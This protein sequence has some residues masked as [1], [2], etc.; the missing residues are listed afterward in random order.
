MNR[1]LRSTEGILCIVL[2]GLL[3]ICLLGLG[4]VL[5][6]EQSLPVFRDVTMEL[7]QPLPAVSAF[8]TERGDPAKAMRVT[9]DEELDLSRV[10]QQQV[11][12]RQN[13]REET[14][15]LTIVDT[16]APAVVSRLDV[17][18]ALGTKPQAQALIALVTDHSPVTISFVKEPEI[19]KNFGTVVME[20]AVTDACGNATTVSCNVHY[21]WL[22]G[23]FALELGQT[24]TVAD[25]LLGEMDEDYFVDQAAVDAIN[26]SGIGVYPVTSTCGDVSCQC[27][28]TVQDTTAPTLEVQSLVLEKGET[29][30]AEEFVIAATDLSGPVT[31]GFQT[32][33]DFEQVGQQTV[34]ITGTDASGNIATAE[35]TLDIKQDMTA[36]V[37]QGLDNMRVEIGSSPDYK[38]GV[39]AVDNKDGNVEFTV[40]ASLEDTSK[41]GGFFVT[42]TAT[43]AAGNTTT[44]RRWI[45]VDHDQSDVEALVAKYADT[46]PDDPHQI[47]IWL[48]QNIIY[49]YAWGDGDPVWFG[50]TKWYGNCYVHAHCLQAILEHKGYETQLIWTTGED[51]YWVLVNIGGEGEAAVW[52]HLDSTPGEI[53]TKYG[54]MDD[55]HRLWTLSGGRV[56]D[57]DQWPACE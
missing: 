40:D 8:L 54:L 16:T 15:T 57:F 12:F 55:E 56:W 4:G 52:R 38:L 17:N 13:G 45:V 35:T 7:G 48:Q 31:L 37:F 9:T 25:L 6:L 46:L 11:I 5:Y 20:V 53:H 14:V 49:D 19:P 29:A 36:P 30:A 18:L 28:V 1:L 2:I 22:K 51:H 3:L 39:V 43:D 10:G 34:V 27:I 50:F 23:T 42:Y 47:S 24:L 21:V 44:M 33:P 26:G 32:Q 41:S